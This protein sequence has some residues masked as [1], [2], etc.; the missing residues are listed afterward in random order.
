MTRPSRIEE[1]RPI[2]V[3]L[4][5][6]TWRFR[7]SRTATLL[8]VLQLVVGCRS[9]RPQFPVGMSGVPDP[10]A[11]PTLREAGFNLV[12]GTASLDYLEAAKREGLGVI[13][14]PG[15]SAGDR[16]FDPV[17]ARETVRRW[18]GH[19]ALRAWYLSDEPDLNRVSPAEITRAAET[20]HQAGA[21]KPTAL[22][23]FD[24]NQ[25]GA[26]A[27]LVDW[28][29][30]DRYPVPWMPLADFAK[31]L[32]LARLAAGPDRPLYAVIQAFDWSLYPEQ[33]KPREGMRPPSEL[34]LRAM[35]YL[36]LVR[37]AQ[38]LLY[39]CYDDGHWRL[40]EHPETWDVLQRVVGE[41]R[42]RER[43]FQGKAEWAGWD[44]RH[45]DAARHRNEALDPA[46]QATLIRV[47]RGDDF[48]PA[49]C[50]LVAVNT[51]A[52]EVPWRFRPRGGRPV[53]RPLPLLDEARQ[54]EMVEGWYSHRFGP[55][56][57]RVFG[58]IAGQF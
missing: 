36:A 53:D 14:F 26:Y 41:V 52:D 54:A 16:M 15:T 35:T 22:V 21:R 39:Y 10:A 1:V 11:F 5:A 3:H 30:Q 48:V 20:L 13:A 7:G 23:L 51:L 34:E 6:G 19:P 49:G 50:Y 58:P 27:G 33:L 25:G 44:F 32:R 46:V 57:V 2:L 43:L 4:C 56:E 24:G 17:R 9:T 18:D 8:A 55:Y 45:P 38:G 42:L 47:Q 29:I 40:R 12:V 31:H 28:L 37:G